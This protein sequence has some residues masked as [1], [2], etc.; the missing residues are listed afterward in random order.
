MSRDSVPASD[1]TRLRE[2]ID[3]AAHLLPA[4]GPI[5]VFVHHNT[6]HSFED[7]PFDEAVQKGARTFGC[8]PYLTK[9]RYRQELSRGR[10]RFAELRDVL[11]EDLGDQASEK[12][13]GGYTRLE[14]RLAMLQYPVRYGPTQELVWFVAEKDALTR[15]REEAS[16]A[17]RQ[18][19]IA[20][21]RRWVMRDLRGGDE[22][23]PNRPARK[24][25]PRIPDSLL[26]VF[27]RFSDSAI[28]NWTDEDWEAFTLQA[29]WG[30]CCAGVTGVPV[31]TPPPPAP[32][33]HR[34]LL[35]EATGADADLLVHEILIRF[36]AAFL[37]QGLAPWQMPYRDDGLY[38]AF[39]ALY[40]RRGGPLSGWMRDLPAE[41]DRLEAAH[42]RP[43]ESI[44]ESLA[45][46]GVA[47]EEWD[48]FVSASLL[49]LRG[50]AGM[51]R[52]IEDR[53]DQVV[54]PV[55]PGSL[56]EFLAVRLVL[57]RLAL[58]HT[59]RVALGFKDPLDTLRAELRRV[60]GPQ[61]PPSI[62]QR[63]FQVFQL[64]QVLGWSPEE[65]HHLTGQDWEMLLRE[66]ET[67]SPLERRR[68]FHRAYRAP[69]LYP[70]ARCSRP[71]RSEGVAEAHAAA[72]PG[73]V[74]HR[75]ARGVDPAPPGRVGPGRGNVLRGRV[76]FRPDV[77]PRR[78]RRA[79]RAPLPGGDAARTLGHRGGG[80]GPG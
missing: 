43:L 37:D 6:L 78:G 40:R 79:F 36:C 27:E 42:V 66:I 21:T 13:P 49:A 8:Q 24:H 69:L 64:A 2:I 73:L 51:V 29:L 75:R 22:S 15:V 32:V 19:L 56:I 53:G 23:V 7:L 46:L 70:D 25:F 52:Q 26:P 65:L 50:W 38:R 68:I 30:I 17:V 12:V 5:T 14:L 61:R 33:R 41:L 59:A 4:Q 44:H 34:D 1:L 67:F 18:R 71:A 35:L 72:F 57:D 3:H 80:R 74:L 28:E 31:F 55:P 62:E 76:L 45:L 47:E 48:D 63:A 16:S 11:A 58:A 54:H 10:I 39:C 60:L 20:E 9:D 77:L